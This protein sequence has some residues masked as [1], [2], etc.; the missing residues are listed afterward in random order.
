MFLTFSGR[1]CVPYLRTMWWPGEVILALACLVIRGGS[2]F[3]DD[4]RPTTSSLLKQLS[5]KNPVKGEIWL[6]PTFRLFLTTFAGK[7]LARNVKY[8]MRIRKAYFTWLSRAVRSWRCLSRC[9]DILWDEHRIFIVAQKSL[10][11]QISV[12]SFHLDFPV[13]IKESCILLL[14]LVSW[15]H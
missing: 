11:I 2:A 1:L 15:N 9:T 3:G 4:R 7:K 13:H 14:P 12:Q 5:S 6:I 8:A 10:F